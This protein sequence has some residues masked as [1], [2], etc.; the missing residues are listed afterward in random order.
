RRQR[1]AGYL[2]WAVDQAVGDGVCIFRFYFGVTAL[3]AANRVL[4]V[5]E[6]AVRYVA[7]SGG[8]VEALCQAAGTDVAR[9]GQAETQVCNNLPIQT[10][11]PGPYLATALVVGDTRSQRKVGADDAGQIAG[12]WYQ[13]LSKSLVNFE[14]AF[15]G[16]AAGAIDQVV[17][18]IAGRQAAIEQVA[19]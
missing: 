18:P 4:L 8:L 19:I 5:S 14:A 16:G 11:F 9:A 1:Q 12:Q 2:A 10:G 15:H 3:N 17:A 7:A 13:G 6:E